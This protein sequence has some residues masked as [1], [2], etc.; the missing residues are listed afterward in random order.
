MGE[1]IVG[2]AAGNQI[3]S[4]SV[5]TEYFSQYRWELAAAA[6]ANAA[7]SWN[8]DAVSDVF[9]STCCCNGNGEYHWGCS[10]FANWRSRCSI[11]DVGI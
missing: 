6:E 9:Y 1:W 7:V 3:F 4:H 10:C 8:H 2:I 5:C 11:L